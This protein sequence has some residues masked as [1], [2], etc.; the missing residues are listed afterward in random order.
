MSETKF[1]NSTSEICGILHSNTSCIAAGRLEPLL[2][3]ALGRLE[4][5][6]KSSREQSQLTDRAKTVYLALLSDA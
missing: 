5:A 4:M 2:P 1:F 3:L 6:T